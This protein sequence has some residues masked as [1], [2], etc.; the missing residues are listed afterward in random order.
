M[1]FESQWY[2]FQDFIL[3]IKLENSDPR[4][5]SKKY[6]LN[7]L[8]KSFYVQLKHLQI[9]SRAPKPQ[10]QTKNQL[11]FLKRANLQGNLDEIVLI[12]LLVCDIFR[13]LRPTLF[14]LSRLAPWSRRRWTTDVCP[15]I[16][17]WKSAVWPS[18]STASTRTS[19]SVSMR[20][21]TTSILL[22]RAAHIKSV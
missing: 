16:A 7:A 15:P 10:S 11:N 20:K 3:F 18:M 5:H 4:K 8:V 14:F 1:F 12:T 9:I 2:F 13:L 19:S 17:A 6:F 22:F 21:F